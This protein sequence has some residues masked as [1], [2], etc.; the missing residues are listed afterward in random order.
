[1]TPPPPFFL[2]FI[3]TWHG[4]LQE[5]KVFWNICV[6]ISLPDP[7]PSPSG[8][9]PFWKEWT[10]GYLTHERDSEED[11]KFYTCVC[12]R[13]LLLHGQ[14]V[15]HRLALYK[16]RDYLSLRTTAWSSLRTTAWSVCVLEVGIVE[17]LGLFIIKIN[18]MVIIKNNSVV[19]VCPRGWRRRNVGTIYH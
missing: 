3:K 15:S 18:T 9:R 2:N 11:D 8:H 7:D 12:V 4:I 5:K 1:M 16:C 14:C 6:Q 19:S 10:N 17:M 13:C